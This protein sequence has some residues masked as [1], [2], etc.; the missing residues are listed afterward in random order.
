MRYM[1]HEMRTPLNIMNLSLGFVE[2]EASQ[3]KAL[4]GSS[5]LSSMLEAIGDI[6]DSC[7]TTTYLLDDFL[8]LDKM[9]GGKL[10]VFF[11][12]QDPTKFLWETFRQ[13]TLIAKQAKVDF[14]FLCDDAAESCWVQSAAIRID[15]M[16]FSQVSKSW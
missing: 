11:E 14:K 7:Q 1:S 10:E 5:H 13:F 15:T 12:E 3:L 2:T 16:K 9:K 4:V 8:T 6:K